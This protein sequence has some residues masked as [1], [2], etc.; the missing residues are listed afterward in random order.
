MTS[1]IPDRDAL[2]RAQNRELIVLAY[3]VGVLR[4]EQRAAAILRCVADD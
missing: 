4:M 1:C 2:I 3:L